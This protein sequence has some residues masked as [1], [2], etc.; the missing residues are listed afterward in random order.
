MI[1]KAFCHCHWE[2]SQSEAGSLTEQIDVKRLGNW[3][4]G[5]NVQAY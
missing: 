3:P 5:Q 2:K 1:V 4:I